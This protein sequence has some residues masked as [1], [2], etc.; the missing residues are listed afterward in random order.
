MTADEGLALFD[1]A[2]AVDSAV[3]LPIR[4]DLAVLRAQAVSAGSTPTLLRRSRPGAGSRR[5]GPERRRRPAR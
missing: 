4:L 1:T 3:L 2:M 5:D